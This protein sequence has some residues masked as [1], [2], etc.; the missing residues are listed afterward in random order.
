MRKW[1]FWNNLI[2]EFKILFEG[3]PFWRIKEW[4]SKWVKVKELKSEKEWKNVSKIDTLSFFRVFS[5]LV[6]CSL[7]NEEWKM[8]FQFFIFQM[9]QNKHKIKIHDINS[10][11]CYQNFHPSFSSFLFQLFILFIFKIFFK[12]L[13]YSQ[14]LYAPST[15]LTQSCF[16]IFSDFFC[17]AF[18]FH[19]Y[20]FEN[21][22][23]NFT[24]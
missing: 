4:K 2:K 3:R 20:K 10:Y 15:S 9:N 21:I 8:F 13:F 6:F 19:F 23:E 12:I 7:K 1:I 14:T 24:D 16:T 17:L 5:F 18:N 22:D 11:V